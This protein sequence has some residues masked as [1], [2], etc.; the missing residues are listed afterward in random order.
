M[1]AAYLADRLSKQWAAGLGPEPQIVIPNVLSWTRV[2]NRGVAFGLLQGLGPVV[3]WL[4]IVVLIG[5]FVY[6][7]RLPRAQWLVRFGV[8]LLIGGAA[9][10]LV[11]RLTAGAVID[12]IAVRGF[13]YIFN[14][15]D[16]LLNTGVVIMLIGSY[17]QG[18]P[19]EPD[20]S[21]ETST[22]SEPEH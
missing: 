6:L 19:E 3:G 8:A 12:F 11:D 5:F 15:S 2:L 18:S 17:L 22:S 4:T 10:N 16:I 1:A 7:V 9:G 13:P 21:P 14:V 20:L